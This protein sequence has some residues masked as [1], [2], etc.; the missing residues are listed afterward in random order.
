MNPPSTCVTLQEARGSQTRERWIQMVTPLSISNAVS[1]CKHLL[2]PNQLETLAAAISSANE[3]LSQSPLHPTPTFSPSTAPDCRRVSLWSHPEQ[4][5]QHSAEKSPCL[6][7]PPVSS[8]PTQGLPSLQ[9]LA[10]GCLLQEAF[11]HPPSSASS[12]CPKSEPLPGFQA[13]SHKVK[14]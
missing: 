5:D 7:Y 10:P 13:G 9:D 14:F 2:L 6:D 8:S 11:P 4:G 12:P 1:T 3:K